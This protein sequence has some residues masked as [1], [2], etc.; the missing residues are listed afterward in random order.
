M[1]PPLCN[2]CEHA[3]HVGRCESF[4]DGKQCKCKGKK[5]WWQSLGD[6]IGEAIGEALF[7]GQQR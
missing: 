3:F 7:G 5:K 4:Y 6:G 1:T 2:F